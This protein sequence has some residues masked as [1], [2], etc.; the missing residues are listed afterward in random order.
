MSE[1]IKDDEQLTEEQKA[2]KE[3]RALY[4][5]NREHILALVKDG[6]LPEPRKITRSERRKLDAADVNIFKIKSTDPRSYHAVKDDLADWIL[7]NIYPNF[8]FD[9]VENNICIFFSD[10]IFGLSYRNDITVK[11]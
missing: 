6:K 2:E 10:Y 8:N 7:D 11:N 5:K 4:E 1:E 3:A 9:D